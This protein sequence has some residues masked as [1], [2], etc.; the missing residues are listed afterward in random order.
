MP[1]PATPQRPSNRGGPA[2]PTPKPLD[3]GEPLGAH[4]TNTVRSRVRK[5]QQQGGGVVTIDDPYADDENDTKPEPKAVKPK[6]KPEKTVKDIPVTTRKRSHSTPRKRVVSDEHWKR[7]RNRASTQSTSRNLPTPKRISEYTVN[8]GQA[9]LVRNRHDDGEDDFEKTRDLPRF[10]KK[11]GTATGSRGPI[12]DTKSAGARKH[13]DTINE[14]DYETDHPKSVEPSELPDRL[15]T[16]SP[17]PEDAWA[18]SEA[19]FSELSRRRKRGPT[20]PPKGGIFAHMIDESRKM[21]GI[22][23]PEPPRPTPTPTTGRGAKIEAWL[24]ETPDPFLDETESKSDMPAP[25]DLKSGRARRSQKMADGEIPGTE[26]EPS[27]ISE[28]RKSSESR[29]KSAV[30]RHSKGKETSSST[31]KPTHKPSKTQ[32][33]EV[34]KESKR[35]SI[36]GTPKPSKP[37]D[38]EVA[39]ES[40][41]ASIDG[42][43]KPSKTRDGEIAKESKRASIDGIPKPPKTQDGE[44]AKESKRASIDGIPKSS[45]KSKEDKPIQSKPYEDSLAP[46]ESDLQP[47]SDGELEISGQNASAP[48]NRKKPFSSTGYQRLSTIP[49]AETLSTTLTDMLEPP[50]KSGLTERCE[51]QL[52]EEAEEAEEAEKDDQFDPDSL[53]VVSSQLKRRLTNHSDLMSVLSVSASRRSTRSNRSIRT[54]K[55]RLAHAT[56]DDLLHE[57]S[58]D[59]TKYMRE[60]KTLVGGVIP[61]LLTCVLSRSD[62]AIAAG[63]FRPS[64]DPEDDLNFSKPIVNMGVAIERLKTLHKRIPQDDADALLTWAQGAQ[65]VYREYLKAWR[66]GFKDVIVNLAPLEEGEATDDAD[67]KSLDEGLERDE[68]GDI[69]D[70][71]GEKVDVAYLLKR[72][73]VRLKYLAKSFKGINLL[74]PSPKAEETA[75]AYQSLVLDARKRVRDERAR[76]EDDCAASIDPTR[77]RDPMTLGVLRGIG[78]DQSRHVRARDF[79]NLSLYHSSGQLVDCRAE[80][81]YRDNPSSKGPGGDLLICEI[82]HSDRWLLFPPMDLRCV[83]ARK[84]ESKHEIVVM[85]R[86]APGDPTRYWQELIS[87]RIDEEEVGAEWISLLGS[88]PIPPSI[89]RSQSFISRAKQNRARKPAAEG[90]PPRP[91]PSDVDIPIGEK[92][93]GKRRSL[94]SKEP[95][96]EPSTI[97]ST[98]TDPRSSLSSI[99]TRETDYTTGGSELSAKPTRPDLPLLP[100]TTSWGSPTSGDRTPTGLKRSKAKRFSRYGEST[101]SDAASQLTV[102]TDNASEHSAPIVTSPQAPSTPTGGRF[103]GEESRDPGSKASPKEK[104]RSR[105]PQPQKKTPIKEPEPESPRVS[106]VP[107]ATLPLIPKIRTPSSQTHLSTPTSFGPEDEEDYPPLECLPKQEVPE[108]PTRSRRKKSRRRRKDDDS[109]PPPPPHRS[110]SPANGKHSQTPVLTPTCGGLKR[111]GSSPLKHEY[112]PSTASDYSETDSDAST[113]RHYSYS[114]SEYSRSAD[115]S[116]SEDDYYSA[117]EDEEHDT[118]KPRATDVITDASSLSPSNSVSQSGYRAVPLQPTKTSK[119]IAS[120]FAWS[121]KG[122]WETLL[123]GECSIVVSPGLIEAFAM[124]SELEANSDPNSSN[125]LI[126]LELTPLVPIRRGTA[127]DI[128]IRSPPTE[129]SQITSSNNIMFRSRNPDECDALYGLINQS[130]INNPTY[131]ALQNARGPFNGHSS[132]FEPAVKSSGGFFGWPRRRKSYRASSSPRS[133]AEGSE[134]SVGTMSSAFSALK[135]FGTSSKMFN[136]SRSTIE[137]RTGR[138]GSIYSGS[139]DSGNDPSPNSGIG[140]IA[141][142][143]KGAD[144]IGLSNAKIRLYARESASKWSDMGAARLT[145]MPGPSKNPSRPGTGVS[146]RGDGTTP[147]GDNDN[148]SG[149]SPPSSGAASP[150]GALA[151]EKRIVIRGKTRGE[152]LLDVCLGENAFERIARTGIAVSIRE[153]NEDASIAQKGGVATG[154]GK[155]FM[156]QMKS[157]AEAAYTFGLVGKL[158]Y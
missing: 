149:A 23:E 128:S 93:G 25:L 137:S 145:I 34:A 8:E 123:P 119:A 129:R 127:I 62:S 22:P 30:S 67:T 106:S 6:E 87:L 143:I 57:L 156:I 36:D 132:T 112:E 18:A 66:L 28:R 94:T 153:E 136:I 146:G 92:A 56:V 98:L 91:N 71:D 52:A 12:R 154:S 5:W 1:S 89:C 121:N 38:G 120:V 135:R 125:P 76:L 43:P 21:F 20:K 83:S 48:L 51:P 64:L 73:L 17:P 81:L 44:V 124:G 114:S 9:S 151:A 41:R 14:S 77:T 116:D 32:D 68:N 2:K 79:F 75:A 105:I 138:E 45:N 42:I 155:I 46:S 16:R 141:A 117:S 72:P 147:H 148:A 118:P 47:L 27:T 99:V 26:S 10:Q 139:G 80:L 78:I 142:A 95:L 122:S 82:D 84:G 60:L 3:I 103:Y 7:T 13:I 54:N 39:K 35:A 37:R 158:R 86:S 65:R 49:S 131:I 40:K 69:V 33:G 113:V 115:L 157:E 88:D 104:S 101:A 31:D 96:S 29:P 15:K 70:S 58:G 109:P 126:S 130:R 111:R 140:R 63:L 11:R 108:T 53:P 102:A 110:P 74:E 61:V 133:L 100:S 107:S 50:P 134:S 59:E 90:S 55:S 4:D 97:G 152:V 24:S 85:L 19:D 144:G 150:R